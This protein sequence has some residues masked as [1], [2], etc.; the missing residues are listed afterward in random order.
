M[1]TTT[2]MVTTNTFHIKMHYNGRSNDFANASASLADHF[3]IPRIKLDLCELRY[4]NIPHTAA[5]KW[6]HVAAVECSLLS[7]CTPSQAATSPPAN[8]YSILWPKQKKINI[9]NAIKNKLCRFNRYFSIVHGRLI[10]THTHMFISN[11]MHTYT[12]IYVCQ[13]DRTN[14]QIFAKSV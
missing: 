9:N 3:N 2:A 6:E 4:R 5:H 11:Y 12:L 8:F 13:S 14:E 1:T 10:C 7:S